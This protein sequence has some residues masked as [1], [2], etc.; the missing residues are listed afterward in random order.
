MMAFAIDIPGLGTPLPPI[1]RRLLGAVILNIE[2]PVTAGE[3]QLSDY[4]FP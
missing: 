3:P 2:A 4:N 1:G